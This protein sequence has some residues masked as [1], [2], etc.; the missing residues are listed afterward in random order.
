METIRW[1]LRRKG[2]SQHVI[3]RVVGAFRD[4]TNR[5]YQSAWALFLNYL[6]VQGISH[7]S[8]SIAV[9]CDFLDYFCTDVE[10]EY[11]T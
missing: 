3:D 4:S 6:S 1:G 2:Y 5:Q 11:R 10:R 7:G 8:I 9:V